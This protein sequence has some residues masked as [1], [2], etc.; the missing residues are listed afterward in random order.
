M[1]SHSL[2]PGVTRERCLLGYSDLGGK[3]VAYTSA[4]QKNFCDDEN[5]L[6]AVPDTIVPRGD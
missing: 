2:S 5:V 4:V 6:C 3:G 1:V